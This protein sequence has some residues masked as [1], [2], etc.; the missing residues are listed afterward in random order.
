MPLVDR[1][2]FDELKSAYYQLTERVTELF[3][4]VAALQTL[5][6]QR[7]MSSA[8]IDE[9]MDLFRKQWDEDMQRGISE[10]IQKSEEE[11]LRAQRQLLESHEGKKQ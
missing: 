9:R 11:K 1:A 5:L 4:R 8:E 6:Q 3:I 10:S 2:E 7:G